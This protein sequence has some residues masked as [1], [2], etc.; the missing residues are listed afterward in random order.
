MFVCKLE[1]I[2]LT[3]PCPTK[4]HRLL[5]QPGTLKP[6]EGAM[7][8]RLTQRPEPRLAQPLPGLRDSPPP[9]QLLL[10]CLSKITAPVKLYRNRWPV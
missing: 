10:E 3:D 7:H 6:P 2:S 9:P 8:G 1:L 5:S 4:G